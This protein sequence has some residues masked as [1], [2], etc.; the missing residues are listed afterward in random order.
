[1]LGQLKGFFQQC[2]MKIGVLGCAGVVDVLEEGFL[3]LKMLRN[4]R[5]QSLHNTCHLGL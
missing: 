3:V 2:A 1:M 5:Y 4:T